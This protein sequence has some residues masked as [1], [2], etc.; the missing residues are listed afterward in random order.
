MNSGKHDQPEYPVGDRIKYFRTQKGFT[1]NKLAN[2]AGVSQS[3]LRDIELENKNP[4]VEFVYQLCK[5]LDI[6]LKEFFNDETA[7]LFADDPLIQR[8][9]Q[10][11]SDQRNALLVF[12]NTIK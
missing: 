11:D 1:V 5:V 9:Y 10:L 12:L 2:M 4:T 3:Y 6:S 7:P 8:I